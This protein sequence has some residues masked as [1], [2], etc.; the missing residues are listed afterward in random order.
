MAAYEKLVIIY[1]SDQSVCFDL[2]IAPDFQ[3]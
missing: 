1:S 3:P 2:D